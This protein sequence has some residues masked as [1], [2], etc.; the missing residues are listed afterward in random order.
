MSLGFV[1]DSM[2]VIDRIVLKPSEATTF[3]NAAGP[4]AVDFSFT[5]RME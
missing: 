3:T 5:A 1:A 2:R 4:D